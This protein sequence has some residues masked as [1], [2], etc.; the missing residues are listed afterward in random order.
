MLAKQ[1]TKN[2]DEFYKKVIEQID[3]TFDL[4]FSVADY[5]F[6]DE[7]TKQSIAHKKKLVD[8]FNNLLEPALKKIE[9][10]FLEKHDIST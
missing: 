4:Q 5:I 7:Y 10:E 3:K 8:R 6:S 9:K 1:K 2:F